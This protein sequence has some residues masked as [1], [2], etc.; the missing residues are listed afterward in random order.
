M[1]FSDVEMQAHRDISTEH[2]AYHSIGCDQDD[3]IA[4]RPIAILCRARTDWRYFVFSMEI[5]S[6]EQ[7]SHRAHIERNF[8]F[9]ICLFVAESVGEPF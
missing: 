5:D 7:A 4:L 2:V 8:S 1:V 3:L 9:F 6:T